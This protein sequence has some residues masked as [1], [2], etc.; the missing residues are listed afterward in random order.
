MIYG[1]SRVSTYGQAKDGNSLQ[2][3]L[4]I[5]EGYNCDEI[6]QETFFRAY[7]YIEKLRNEQIKPWLFKVAYNLFI[8]RKRK[9]KKL[10][11]KNDEF[12]DIENKAINIEEQIITQERLK[13]IFNYISELPVKQKMLYF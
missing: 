7:V 12:F 4:R 8:D 1:Y 13:R 9:D 6:V 5:L 3:Q 10:I 11:H 2:D